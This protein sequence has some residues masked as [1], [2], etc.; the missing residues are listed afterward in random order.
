M[1]QQTQK[2][3][4]RKQQVRA[5]Y[6]DVCDRTLE[7]AVNDGRRSPSTTESRSGTRTCSKR[8]SVPPS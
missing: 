7:R 3:W 2:R 8:T 6:G 4:L 5:R 1:L